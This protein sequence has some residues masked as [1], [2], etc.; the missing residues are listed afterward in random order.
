MKF[1]FSF[2]EKYIGILL[3]SHFYYSSHDPVLYIYPLRF[4]YSYTN[5]SKL[6]LN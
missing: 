3:H 1:V 4:A 6:F 2:A 5:S